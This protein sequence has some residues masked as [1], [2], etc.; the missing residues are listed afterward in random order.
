MILFIILL[1]CIA[2][3]LLFA[4]FARKTLNEFQKKFSD[5][6]QKLKNLEEKFEYLSQTILVHS[7]VQTI[8]NNSVNRSNMM[9][10]PP[11]E[12]QKISQTN[13]PS[14]STHSSNRPYD[15]THSINRPSDL[16]PPFETKMEFTTQPFEKFTTLPSERSLVKTG[17][18]SLEGTPSNVNQIEKTITQQTPFVTQLVNT[19]MYG[20]TVMNKNNTS[21]KETKSS[22]PMSKSNSD[23]ESTPTTASDKVASKQASEIMAIIQN[24]SFDKA[25]LSNE[26]EIMESTPTTTLEKT[27]LEKNALDNAALDKANETMESTPNETMESTPNE[28]MED[29][30]PSENECM[31]S[32]E[33]ESIQQI[34]KHPGQNNQMFMRTPEPDRQSHEDPMKFSSKLN[35]PRN[36]IFTS[37]ML[38][39]FLFDLNSDVVEVK[40]NSKSREKVII[41][42]IND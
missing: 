30:Q 26:N 20:G 9:N 31:G 21:T 42:E 25:T 33:T 19:Q 5:D 11:V 27:A 14:D 3:F 7:D 39:D 16:T 41:T 1:I 28:T 13:R 35:D 23:I 18:Q 34:E 6:Q 12:K 29:T 2:I 38:Y 32:S 4:F 36:E 37:P 8:V 24:P 17:R 15:L 22:T 40:K 10:K